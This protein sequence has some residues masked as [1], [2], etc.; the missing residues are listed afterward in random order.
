MSTDRL[1]HPVFRQ[2]YAERE[3]VKEERRMRVDTNPEGKLYETFV[4]TAYQSH[5]YRNPTI[6]WEP[7]RSSSIGSSA[8]GGSSGTGSA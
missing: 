7:A 6:G 8:D 2:F 3:V 5:P 1:R 4:A